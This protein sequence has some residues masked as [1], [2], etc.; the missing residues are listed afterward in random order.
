VEFDPAGM[1]T[2]WNPVAESL[3]CWT[4]QEVLGRRNP[5]IPIETAQESARMQLRL[6]SGE[7]IQRLETV[8]QRKDGS[9]IPVEI[10]STMLHDEAGVMTG[11]VGV[12]VDISER[13]KIEQQLRHA[14]YHD[15]L[16]GLPNRAL[17]DE[18]VVAAFHRLA[19]SRGV[20]TMLMLDLNGFK[21]INDTLGHAAGDQL[22]IA[23]ARRLRTQ[24]RAS[25]TVARLGGDEFVVLVDGACSLAES[26][27]E[28]I[29]DSLTVPVATVAGDLVVGISVGIASTHVATTP[30]QELLRR[31]D[32]AMYAAKSDPNVSFRVA[33]A[34]GGGAPQE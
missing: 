11:G 19:R 25:D 16:T 3:F 24:V 20:L 6:L 13:R 17:F 30:P 18:H 10:T 7:S 12:I 27:A 8:R 31:A 32:V 22:L 34:P 9:R 23:V 2:L 29:I 1:I 21:K 4:A 5:T 15:A 28:R 14:A 26:L 33:P